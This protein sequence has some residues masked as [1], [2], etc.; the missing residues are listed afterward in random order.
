MSP[1]EHAT[2][3]RALLAARAAAFAPGE[4]VGQESFVSAGEVLS[5]ARRAGVAPGISVL[6]L[7]CG[8]AGPGL[9]ITRELGCT[10]LGVDASPASVTLARQRAAREG[11]G[12]RF[13][14]A[15][16]PPIPA[17]RFD[18]VLLLETLLAFRDKEA[19][20]RAVASAL[21]EGGRFAF[22]VEEGTPLTPVERD[23]MPGSD[24][25]WLTPLPDLVSALERAGLLVRWHGECSEAHLATVDALTGA[26]AAA[27]SRGMTEYPGRR[28][29]DE[30]LASHRLWSRW[31][32]YGRVRK[33]VV[34]AEK[35]HRHR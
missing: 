30:L 19:L 23:L 32:R 12:C 4:F 13:H 9:F 29:V 17:G 6:D 16:V 35:P 26:Y 8:T 33:F 28:A 22:T 2:I 11:L 21:P 34:V 1:A 20:L 31:L 25:V 5:L 3:D 10:Y 24:T 7:C 18:V 14:V 15:R 27:A